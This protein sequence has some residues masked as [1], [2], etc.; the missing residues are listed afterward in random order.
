MKRKILPLFAVLAACFQPNSPLETIGILPKELSENSAAEMIGTTLWTVQDHGNSEEIFALDLDGKIEKRIKIKGVK[1]NDW[2][3]L[4]S[5]KNGNLY[6]G[7]MGNNDNT[8]RDL[9]IYK[10]DAAGLRKESASI[11]Q[12][13]SFYYPEQK[14]FPPK[15]SELFYDCE[16]F[17]EHDGNFY[18]FTKNRS[19]GFDGTT[20]LYKVPNQPGNFAA[21]KTGEFKTCGNFH[22]CAVT[23]ADISPDGKKVLLLTA[24]KIFLFSGFPGDDF[25]NGNVRQIDLKAV[26]QKE[27]AGF[28]DDHT[29]IISEEG[30]KKTKLYK[31]SLESESDTD[32]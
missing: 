27:G 9:A 15:K 13:T 17:F 23:A 14:S 11:S 31:L 4:G 1:N 28:L 25:L 3:E 18:L 19:K 2:E 10:I 30:S 20:F 22:G 5:D 29:I 12:K 7:D 8:R 6:I 26:S 32:E 24:D 21:K 16:A